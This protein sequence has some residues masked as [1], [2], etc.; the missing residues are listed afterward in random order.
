MRIKFWGVRGSIPAPLTA[1]QIQHRISAIVQRITAR[2]IESADAR[3]SFLAYLPA[4]LG[5][6]VGGNTSCVQ[7]LAADGNSFIL[8]AGSGIR[9]L[10]NSTGESDR[11]VFHLF[12]SHFH[13]DHIMGLP[14]FFPAYNKK[15]TIHFY[16]PF[17]DMKNILTEQMKTPY[18]PI[19]MTGERGFSAALHFH[20]ITPGTPFSIGNIVIN[21][22]KMRHPGDSYSYSFTEGDRKCIY[23]T[24]V[25]L[26]PADFAGTGAEDTFFK[27][28]DVLVL[29]A[30]YTLE[31]SLEKENWGH[32][33]FSRAI[34]FSVSWNVN[35]LFLFHH[36]PKYDDKK[37]NSI[38]QAAAWYAND[39]AEK[40]DISIY[41][42]GEGT[43]VDV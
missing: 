20:T 25:E 19:P 9:E 15:N 7:V 24:D 43:E 39:Y 23:T 13:W 26:T 34:D 36:E 30:Q 4:W 41:L 14:F 29:D 1:E 33:S 12:F 2:D 16:S 3:E 28:A 21:T 22:K 38:L 27:N 32:S 17:P 11:R 42:A 8:D 40:S 37:L 10:G 5:S 35:R 6:T 31:E 18:F